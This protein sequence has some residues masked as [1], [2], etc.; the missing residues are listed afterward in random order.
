MGDNKVN[1]KKPNYNHLKTGQQKRE[2]QIDKKGK[3][4]D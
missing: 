4:T 3:K 1:V 2:R